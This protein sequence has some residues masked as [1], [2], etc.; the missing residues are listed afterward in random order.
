MKTH[1]GAVRHE[2]YFICRVEKKKKWA[3]GWGGGGAACGDVPF[4]LFLFFC[5]CL[6]SSDT[7]VRIL[8]SSRTTNWVIRLGATLYFCESKRCCGECLTVRQER[9][10]GEGGGSGEC[11]CFA[12]NGGVVVFYDCGGETSALFAQVCC[13]I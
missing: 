11:E 3:G 4:F 5:V 1:T 10:G 2:Q 13:Y 6:Y 9:D 12:L 7:F 8:I